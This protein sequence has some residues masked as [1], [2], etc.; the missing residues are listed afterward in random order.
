MCG[1]EYEA[2]IEKCSDCN[3]V[4]VTRMPPEN[5]D[6]DPDATLVGIYEADGDTE[7]LVVK[8]LL[9]SEGIWC[10]L[11][12]DVPHTVIPLSVDGLGVV[13]VMV[14]ERDAERAEQIISKHRKENERP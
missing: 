14:S 2:G 1:S 8:G 10:S 13:R 6:A 5:P 3:V 9:E 12:S 4:L 7:A 11:G